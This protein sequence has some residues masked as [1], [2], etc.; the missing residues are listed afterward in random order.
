MDDLDPD[1]RVR[2][3]RYTYKAEGHDGDPILLNSPQESPD[4]RHDTLVLRQINSDAENKVWIQEQASQHFKRHSDAPEGPLMDDAHGVIVRDGQAKMIPRQGERAATHDYKRGDRVWVE[5]SLVPT[6]NIDKDEN[7]IPVIDLESLRLF[8]VPYDYICF[9]PQLSKRSESGEHH[10][11]A[12]GSVLNTFQEK[13]KTKSRIYFR[14]MADTPDKV[15]YV[16]LNKKDKHDLEEMR[17]YAKIQNLDR[18]RRV[19]RN[20]WQALTKKLAL[21][22]LLMGDEVIPG[23]VDRFESSSDSDA[24]DLDLRWRTGPMGSSCCNLDPCPA[25]NDP[26]LDLVAS[27]IGGYRWM[28]HYH[29]QDDDLDECPRGAEH[30][31]HCVLRDNRTRCAY[32]TDRVPHTCCKLRV[33]PTLPGPDGDPNDVTLPLW[34][35]TAGDDYF[36]DATRNVRTRKELADRDEIPPQ[37]LQVEKEARQSSMESG[38]GAE[39]S[40]EDEADELADE[41]VTDQGSMEDDPMTD[42]SVEGDSMSDGSIRGDSIGDDSLESSSVE[43]N[44]TGHIDDARNEPTRPQNSPPSPQGTYDDTEM[45]T[46]NPLE[47]IQ[48]PLGYPLAQAQTQQYPAPFYQPTYD[49]FPYPFPEN[50]TFDVAPPFD[51][52]NMFDPLYPYAPQDPPA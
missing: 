52:T 2:V 28:E 6:H 11:A 23:P 25:F 15:S 40:D 4:E 39:E 49:M 37:L 5:R 8:E 45:T 38:D 17:S 7:R 41:N 3:W 21:L 16:W 42:N 34:E 32:A 18:K 33:N 26:D 29:V 10:A 43:E 51:P 20:Q 35:T 19:F 24:G 1:F 48:H 12:V 14:W 13:K 36:V 9:V 31:C 30:K 50:D 46:T 22:G 44:S 47:E 27:Y